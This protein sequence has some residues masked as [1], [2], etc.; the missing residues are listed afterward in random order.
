MAEKSPQ[1]NNHGSNEGTPEL[2]FCNAENEKEKTD[3]L[4][5][6]AVALLVED[7]EVEGDQLQFLPPPPPELKLS[8]TSITNVAG[9]R[10]FRVEML[11]HCL[12]SCIRPNDG[13]IDM[14]SYLDSFREIC[15]LLDNLGTVIRAYIGGDIR[16]KISLIKEY[17]AGQYG[18]FYNTIEKMVTFEKRN[19]IHQNNVEE[20]GSRTVLRLHRSLHFVFEFLRGLNKL[21]SD[22]GLGSMGREVYNM[23]LAQ[24]HPWAYKKIARL[25]L[26]TLGGKKSLVANFHDGS[27]TASQLHDVIETVVTAATRVHNQCQTIYETHNFLDLP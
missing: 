12:E 9:Y 16:Q 26:S 25:A 2:K 3:I 23:T 14:D 24:N 8:S 6:T 7:P 21:N 1:N 15:K 18:S 27:M 17:K 10:N 13:E 11:A 5:D 20:N 19:R 4:D 22:E